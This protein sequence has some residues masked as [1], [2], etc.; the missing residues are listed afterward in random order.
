MR[1]ETLPSTRTYMNI[2]VHVRGTCRDLDARQRHS[3]GLV[4]L[5]GRIEASLW[6]ER[7]IIIYWPALPAAETL[8]APRMPQHPPYEQ[9][10]LHKASSENQKRHHASE[11]KVS[12][13]SSIKRGRARHG[14]L[15]NY[16][17][18]F[19]TSKR[20]KESTTGPSF[21]VYLGWSHHDTKNML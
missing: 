19:D 12:K 13:K 20:V 6:R 7:Q 17:P 5:S 11:E 8:L 10:E 4:P 18:M 2:L 21:R 9:P 16:N 3:Q 1:A 15:L 14:T